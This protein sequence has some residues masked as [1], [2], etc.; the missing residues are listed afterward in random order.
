ML[1]K[2]LYS[3]SKMDWETPQFLYDKLHQE[4]G[5]TLD[6]CATEENAKCDRF[7]SP[8]VDGLVQEWSGIVWMNPPYGR[9]ISQWVKKAHESS[10]AWLGTVANKSTE[11]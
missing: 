7:F 8:D 5:F 1:N 6:A 10:Q 3:S 11:I 2:S 4:F 9:E